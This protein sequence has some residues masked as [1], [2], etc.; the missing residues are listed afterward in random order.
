MQSA[1]E[2]NFWFRVST[3]VRAHVARATF[4]RRPRVASCSPRLLP[5]SLPR[6]EERRVGKECIDQSPPEQLTKGLEQI[7][8]AGSRRHLFDH[9]IVRADHPGHA[10][11]Y[12]CR[13]F[14]SNESIDGDV[15][16][17]AFIV[18]FFK[19]KTAYEIFT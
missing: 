17:V 18:F 15:V 12:G 11:L 8:D 3:T 4:V 2:S 16:I 9:V 13:V 14:R 6:S 1:T 10:Q 19:Q 5:S 7:A